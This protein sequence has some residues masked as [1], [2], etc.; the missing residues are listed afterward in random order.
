MRQSG[1]AVST[2]TVAA[3]QP[4]VALI[5]TSLQFSD[6][7]LRFLGQEF[8]GV[9]FDRIGD[10]RDL[11]DGE[12]RSDVVVLHEAVPSLDTRISEIRATLPSA[13]IAVACNDCT[14]LQ[15]LNLSRFSPPISP[16]QMNAQIDI[17]LAVL[18]LLLSGH[19][20]VPVA[21][22]TEDEPRAAAPALP[23]AI[24][25]RAASLLTRR[26]MEVLPL[27]A[28]GKQNKVIAAELDLSEH[29]VKLHIHN[30]F[31]KLGVSNRTGA[32]NW[33]LSQLED[34]ADVASSAAT[35]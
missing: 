4:H 13:L 7:I 22:A 2:A 3:R 5:G 23:Q 14:I 29:T 31:A 26:E 6:Q 21:I 33:Y 17:W 16:L 35:G 15:R 11:L 24:E 32:A 9:H 12:V 19:V 34:G 8:E 30:I 10:P 25:S 18:R 20:W 28:Q 27:L 1:L